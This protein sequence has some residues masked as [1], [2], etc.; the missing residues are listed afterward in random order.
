MLGAVIVAA[1][2][3]SAAGI[4]VLRRRGLDCSGLGD[5]DCVSGDFAGSLSGSFQ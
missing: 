3:G 1:D 2:A 4:R 5:S